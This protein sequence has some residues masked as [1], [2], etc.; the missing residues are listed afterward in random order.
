[1][2]LFG[3]R[4]TTGS[5]R[6]LLGGLLVVTIAVGGCRAA[7]GEKED[8]TEPT[9]SQERAASE[10]AGEAG[11]SSKV[12]PASQ[13]DQKTELQ[14]KIGKGLERT[15]L[16][17]LSPDRTLV[18]RLKPETSQLERDVAMTLSTFQAEK[19]DEQTTR[20]TLP[21]HVLFDFDSYALRPEA[22]E[23]IDKLVQV[24]EYAGDKAKVTIVGHTDNVGSAEYNQTLSEKRAQAVLEAL[25][26]R[27]IERERMTAIGKGMTEPVADNA[28]EAGR[29]KNR[30]VEI[31]IEGSPALLGTLEQKRNE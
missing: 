26:E 4:G 21:N 16:Y 6:L 10:A 23:T 15:E 22:Q 13:Q 17:V 1:M 11:E 18:A 19:T 27:G 2:R 31:L 30:R 29:Q 20:L 28:T 14:T 25:A 5:L 7:S 24:L 8:T 9:A 3:R 12:S